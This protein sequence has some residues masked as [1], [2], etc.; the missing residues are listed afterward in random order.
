MTK[1]DIKKVFVVGA[2]TMGHG[3]AQAFAQRGYQVSLFSPSQKTLDRA[4][5][6]LQL[7]T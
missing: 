5:A 4:M 6:I 3:I 7:G 1:A 2:G